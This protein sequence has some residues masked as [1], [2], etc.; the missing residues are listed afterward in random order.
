MPWA[1]PNARF[2][3]D[4]EDVVAWLAQR[5]DKTAVTRLLRTSWETV[6]AIVNAIRIA[7]DHETFGGGQARQVD[8]LPRAHAVGAELN[9]VWMNLLDNALDAGASL[10][11]GSHAIEVLQVADNAVRTARIRSVDSSIRSRPANT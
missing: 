11:V 5:M 7:L 6:A 10:T 4:F 9:Q 8:D 1:R 2:T 3:R